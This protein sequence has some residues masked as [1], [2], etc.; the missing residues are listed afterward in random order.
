VKMFEVG[1]GFMQS[2]RM[3]NRKGWWII[4]WNN[5]KIRSRNRFLDTWYLCSSD[6]RWITI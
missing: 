4:R 6:R 2:C 5:R 1:R 3:S